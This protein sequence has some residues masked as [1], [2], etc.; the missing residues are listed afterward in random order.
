MYMIIDFYSH[1]SMVVIQAGEFNK[2]RY[3]GYN[4]RKAMQEYRRDNGLKHKHMTTIINKY[5]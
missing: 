5:F 3:Y 2:V 1:N 4:I